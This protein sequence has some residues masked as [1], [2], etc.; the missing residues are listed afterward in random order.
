[1]SEES[2]SFN[3]VDQPW[4]MVCMVDGTMD[5]LSIR[6]LFTRAGSIAC[7][8]NELPTVDFSVLR[9]LLAILQ[10][11]IVLQADEWDDPVE[12]WSELWGDRELPQEKIDTYLSSWHDKFDL[13]DDEYPFMQ[14]AGMKP[15]NP[16]KGFDEI[17][18]IIPDVPDKKPLFALRWGDS[19]S[20]IS[21][22]EAARWLVHAQAFDL[23]GIKTGMFGDDAVRGNRRYSDSFGTGWSGKIGGL[24]FEGQTLLET[25]LLNLVLATRDGDQ[26]VPLEDKPS[27]ER[28]MVDPFGG[29]REPQGYA[30]VYTWQSRRI[31][32]KAEGDR[33]VGV[34]LTYGDKLDP[35]NRMAVEPMTAWRLSEAQAKKLKLSQVL[36]PREHI[37]EQSLWR[38]FSSIV[39]ASPGP[40][41]VVRWLSEFVDGAGVALDGDYRLLIRS[42]GFEYGT[43]Q[44]TYGELIS[45]SLDIHALLLSRLDQTLVDKVL[46]CIKDTDEAISKALVPFAENVARA[47]GQS[48]KRRAVVKDKARVTAYSSIDV[49]FRQ[50]L[51]QIDS[52]AAPVKVKNVW[53]A[54]ARR[55]LR[56]IAEEI[57]ADAGPKAAVGRKDGGAWMSTPLAMALFMRGLNEHLPLKERS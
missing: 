27:W 51:A 42:V 38:G 36:M 8:Q 11:A 32:L 50:W 18:T 54:E 30:D 19:V 9:V 44:S 35:Q 39:P 45:D 56:S 24:Y 7:L 14:V 2:R 29:A 20:S 22:A 13:L 23:S 57:G 46:K 31:L 5:E 55:A 52:T 6:E 1:M 4:I 15:A 37:S 17:R 26:L 33:A 43:Q 49:S 41:G 10:R 53:F 12:I 48:E 34:L 40:P 25:L 16:K 47:Q 21:L 3:L 28:T